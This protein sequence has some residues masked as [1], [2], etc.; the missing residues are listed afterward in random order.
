LLE[1]P[2]VENYITQYP[3][4][5]N[6]KIL[7]IKYLTLKDP[8]GFENPEGLCICFTLFGGASRSVGLCVARLLP[9]EQHKA[10]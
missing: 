10:G 8:Q 6:N 7:K 2:V 4:D 1:S 9:C 3:I 5:G